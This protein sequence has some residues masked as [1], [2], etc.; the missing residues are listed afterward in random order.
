M[1]QSAIQIDAL[2]P[3]RGNRLSYLCR[4]QE[5]IIEKDIHV[6][7]ARAASFPDG[8]M[9]A[10]RLLEKLD[11]EYCKRDFYGLSR[12]DMSGGIVYWACV[13]SSTPEEN[14]PALE[15]RVIKEGTYAC[16]EVTNFRKNTS[17]IGEAFRGLLKHPRLDPQGY[18][19]EIYGASSVS[20][21]VRL[22]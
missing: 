10:F 1:P 3:A 17:L 21:M 2:A 6:L 8:I 12:G 18:C 14:H 15:S 20:C 9:S 4:M 11:P 5:Q 16:V 13:R 7:C 22:L 19:V